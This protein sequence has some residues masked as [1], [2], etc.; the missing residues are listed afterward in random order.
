M[1]GLYFAKQFERI[2]SNF[3]PLD[4]KLPERHT[5]DTWKDTPNKPANKHPLKDIII[6]ISHVMQ[7][8][9]DYESKRLVT[10]VHISL[11][12]ADQSDTRAVKTITRPI[13]I[14]HNVLLFSPTRAAAAQE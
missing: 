5:Q 12:A 7:E 2:C 13:G 14:R 8:Q 9:A 1:E 6:H 3:Q 10:F 11:S 4:Y